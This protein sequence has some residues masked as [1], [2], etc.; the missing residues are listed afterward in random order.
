[1]DLKVLVLFTAI[2]A[3]LLK[4]ILNYLKARNSVKNI[5][6]PTSIPLI[7]NIEL[8]F[9][10]NTNQ[11]QWFFKNAKNFQ[12]YFKMW[13]GTE[14]WVVIYD[15]EMAEKVLTNPKLIKSN[16]YVFLKPWLGKGLLLNEETSMGLKMNSQNESNVPYVKAVNDLK[17]VSETTQKVISER[18]KYY[19]ERPDELQESTNELGVRKRMPLIDTLLKAH[20]DGQP[21]SNRDIE[22]EVNTFLFAGHDTTSHTLGYFFYNVA[23]HPEVQEKIFE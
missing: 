8:A 21:L 19:A 5:D 4:F 23:K 6:G 3:I 7:G 15:P 11:L 16:D 14:L 12:K 20:V 1:M 22:D 9:L 2:A 10:T 18:R 17:V 13:L